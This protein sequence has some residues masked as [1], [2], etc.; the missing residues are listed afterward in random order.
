MSGA[1]TRAVPIN[2]VQLQVIHPDNF[3]HR[4]IS[5][6]VQINS[7]KGTNSIRAIKSSEAFTPC[8]IPHR[9]YPT[10]HSTDSMTCKDILQT[11]LLQLHQQGWKC[12]ENEGKHAAHSQGRL[13]N[14]KVKVSASR[15]CK[16]PNPQAPLQG[17]IAFSSSSAS[18]W[19]TL[20]LYCDV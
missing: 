16:K 5:M 8:L 2:T 9:E 3:S 1:A 10:G 11:P 7:S 19:A 18:I 12:Q 17:I 15:F 14:G 20:A 13:T 4:I 6:Q